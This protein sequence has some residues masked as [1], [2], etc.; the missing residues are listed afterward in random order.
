VCA[1]SGDSSARPRS[2]RATPPEAVDQAAMKTASTPQTSARSSARDTRAPQRP[3]PY[4]SAAQTRSLLAGSL[5]AR[6]ERLQAGDM[7]TTEQAAEL[8]STTRVTINAWIVKGRA[9]GLTQ[10]RR[11]FRL[12]KWQFEP[13]LWDAIPELAKA[14]GTSEGWTLLS[15]LET[16]LGGLSGRTP[17]QAIEQGDTSRVLELASAEG[18]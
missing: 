15:F 3:S 6:T 9:I 16:P 10:T 17:R 7:V 11:G 8:A 18:T 1:N 14:L 13:G 4:V 5:A 2:T 12:P